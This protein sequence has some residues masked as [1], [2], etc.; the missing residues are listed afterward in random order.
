MRKKRCKWLRRLGVHLD[1]FSGVRP[2]SSKTIKHERPPGM[3]AGQVRSANKD[4]LFQLRAQ[5]VLCR[6]FGVS[7][8]QLYNYFDKASSRK[9]V[10]GE[11]LL[12]FLEQRLDNVVYRMGFASTRR[13]AR[14]LVSHR[15]VI[16][17]RKKKDAQ[18]NDIDSESL[19]DRP[20]FQVRIGD[21]IQ[22]RE[23]AKKQLRIAAALQLAEQNL[24]QPEWVDVDTQKLAG[25]FK[26]IPSR[27]QLP[28]H[29]NEQL[30][31]ELYS[32]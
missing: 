32:K 12:L 10:T 21:I 27:S 31:V 7:P 30:V 14:Q 5:Q 15:A 29:Y 2:I 16:V 3:H 18:G 26:S 1:L 17:I 4:Y 13:E 24:K 11:I 23:K 25:V 6:E 8:K 19:V 9:G 28:A 20:S 22:I